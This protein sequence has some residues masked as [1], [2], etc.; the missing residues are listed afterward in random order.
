MNYMRDNDYYVQNYMGESSSNYALDSFEPADSYEVRM[1]INN[2]ADK[3]ELLRKMTAEQFAAFDTQLYLDTHSC[4]K[5]A[6]EMFNQY[7]RQHQKYLCEYE[8]RFGPINSDHTESGSWDW[9]NDPWP[10]ER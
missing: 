1:P 9:I 5:E 2:Y 3:N 10:W 7:N 8:S 6:L 4:D